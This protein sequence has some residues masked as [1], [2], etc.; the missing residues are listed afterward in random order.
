MADDTT[1]PAR[2]RPEYDGA[3]VDAVHQSPR[4]SPY[5]DEELHNLRVC[6]SPD[7]REYAVDHQEAVVIWTLLD[8]I[9]AQ[10]GWNKN[11]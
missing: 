5:T 4:R 10:K 7:N 11:G 1:P 6:Y 8:M 3:W 9:E 2:H